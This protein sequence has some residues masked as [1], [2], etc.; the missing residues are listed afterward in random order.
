MPMLSHFGGTATNFADAM[1]FPLREVGRATGAIVQLTMEIH[2]HVGNSMVQTSLIG[3]INLES[4]IG[5]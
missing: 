1:V 5:I 3:K 2:V 4:P